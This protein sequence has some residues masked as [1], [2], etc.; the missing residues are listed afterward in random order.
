[1]T[2][3]VSRRQLGISASTNRLAIEEL[4]NIAEVRM[5]AADLSRARAL[6]ENPAH[7]SAAALSPLGLPGGQT[8]ASAP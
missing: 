2:R 5:S 4:R 1:M 6:L 7:L 8:G 3:L